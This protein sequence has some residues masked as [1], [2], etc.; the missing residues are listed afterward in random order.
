MEGGQNNNARQPREIM[1]GMK[2]MNLK[3]FDGKYNWQIFTLTADVCR[4]KKK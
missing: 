4:V 2:M 1:N 3:P